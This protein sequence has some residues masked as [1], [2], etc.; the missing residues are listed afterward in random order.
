[1]GTSDYLFEKGLV[2]YYISIT[3]GLLLI[4]AGLFN[5][6]KI[7]KK[8]KYFGNEDNLQNRWPFA[9]ILVI[10]GVGFFIGTP[11]RL[12]ELRRIKKYHAETIGETIFERQRNPQVTYTFKVNSKT[13]TGTSYYP[14]T[15][16]D[17]DIKVPG[18][19]YKVIYNR[20]NPNE[21]VMD[22]KIKE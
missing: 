15:D 16:F 14:Q 4:A 13:Y 10:F 19:H 9:I 5:F 17:A 7:Y 8:Q 12:A 2:E 1:M 20:N 6:Y 3:I 21:S 18:G 11:G 22:F